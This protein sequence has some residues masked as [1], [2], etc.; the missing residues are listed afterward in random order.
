MDEKEKLLLKIQE[1]EEENQKLKAMMPKEKKP[2]RSLCP[3]EVAVKYGGLMKKGI[4]WEYNHFPFMSYTDLT[5]LSKVIRR[6]CFHRERKTYTYMA[7]HDK[8]YSTKY[9]KNADCAKTLKNLS[10]E[11]YAK[12]CEILD[13]CLAIFQEYGIVQNN[14]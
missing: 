4:A 14:Y 11:E 5:D 6:C 3:K 10:D 12:Y 8:T 9:T 7:V 1:L 13:K 2:S